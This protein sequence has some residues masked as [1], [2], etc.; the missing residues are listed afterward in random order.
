MMTSL[1]LHLSLNLLI[2][3]TTPT[4]L[5]LVHMLTTS[6]LHG[7]ITLVTAAS[8]ISGLIHSIFNSFFHINLMIAIPQHL[9]TTLF[10]HL[11]GLLP[12]H[13]ANL[14]VI[15]LA[16]A[17]KSLTTKLC[18]LTNRQNFLTFFLTI[19]AFTIHHSTVIPMKALKP[20]G[21]RLNI[22]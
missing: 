21:T 7:Q 16:L 5:T 3:Y 12:T 4:C 2:I 13:I 17:A 6:T 22:Q 19:L 15:I 11:P 18:Q 8:T 10:L 9:V 1:A 20:L 14:H